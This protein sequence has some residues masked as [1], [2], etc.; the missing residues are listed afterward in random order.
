[1]SDR[2]TNLALMALMVLA[3]MSGFAAFSIGTSPGLWVV[4]SHGVFGLGVLVL[5]PWKSSIA[6]RGF[7][8]H[9]STRWVSTALALGV[10]IT[11]ASG[12]LLITGV[13]DRIGP[14]TTMQVHV[15]AGLTALA[16][17][18]VHYRQRPVTPRASDLTRRNTIRA[19]SLL[20]AA[21]VIYAGGE[22]VLGLIGA[23]GADR[24]FT[25]SHEIDDND[26]PPA[27]QWLN[28]SVRVID[29][30]AH[31]MTTPTGDYRFADIDE[32]GD[33][34]TATL[35]CTGGWYA[36][37]T[38]SGARL[39]RVL[40][41]ASGE[42]VVIRSV[43]GY[44]RR[45]PLDQS[46]DLLLASR[47]EGEPLRSGNGAPMRLVAPGRRGFWWVKWVDRIEVDDSPPWWQPP[48]PAA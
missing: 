1:M 47:L 20:G 18:A 25:G 26:P 11:L 14:L 4:V 35:D 40:G 8:R 43:T 13:A 42:S 10:V 38:W 30:N 32:F 24:R 45:F 41:D 44:W 19:A 21:G 27:T 22:W 39:D 16:L 23:P 48:L 46:K 36:T 12:I 33:T 7:S 9:G 3:V 31:V 5:T 15:G 34:M 37:R 2:R 29:R 28:D 6:K 17:T